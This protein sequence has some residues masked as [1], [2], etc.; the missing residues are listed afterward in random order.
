M[1]DHNR[2]RARHGP[3]AQ[4][5]APS[6]LVPLSPR[7]LAEI[8]VLLPEHE[9]AAF[10]VS[11]DESLTTMYLEAYTRLVQAKQPDDR[12]SKGELREL[13][14]ELDRVAALHPA[15]KIR[16]RID[17][18]NSQQLKL[19]PQATS[20]AEADGLLNKFTEERG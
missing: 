6:D 4:R 12:M 19:L 8:A 17:Q 14:D 7:R 13:I 11:L 16:L 1:S 18:L 5:D 9:R 15:P 20:Q 3:S 2:R 10:T